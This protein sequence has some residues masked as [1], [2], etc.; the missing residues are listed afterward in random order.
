MWHLCFEPKSS[1]CSFRLYES[2]PKGHQP[3]NSNRNSPR[4]RTEDRNSNFTPPS[5]NKLPT[6]QKR[7]EESLGASR[8]S[9]RGSSPS[10]R[11]RRRSNLSRHNSASDLGTPDVIIEDFF[12]EEQE[13]GVY[14]F[15]TYSCLTLVSLK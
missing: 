4:Q 2:P 3:G 12:D 9:S 1:C 5:R 15:V 10:P 6:P 7:D 8:T 13:H 11:P 14:D